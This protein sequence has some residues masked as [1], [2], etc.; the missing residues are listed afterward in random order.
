MNIM[1]IHRGASEVAGWLDQSGL[2][3]VLDLWAAGRISSAEVA[4]IPAFQELS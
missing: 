3:D 4:A 1:H 2:T